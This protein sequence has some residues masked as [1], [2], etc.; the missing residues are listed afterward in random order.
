MNTAAVDRILLS[1][2]MILLGHR[3]KENWRRWKAHVE[4]SQKSQ[5]T[6]DKQDIYTHIYTHEIVTKNHSGHLA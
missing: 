2:D 4:D 1:L 6:V 5:L 3:L